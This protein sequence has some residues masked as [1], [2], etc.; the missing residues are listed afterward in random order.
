MNGYKEFEGKTLDDAI[1][2]ACSYYDSTRDRLE[3]EILNDSKYGIFGLVGAKKARIRAKLVQLP[4]VLD[5]IT[6]TP[7]KGRQKKAVATGG[8]VEPT[9]RKSRDM[10]PAGESSKKRRHDPAPKLEGQPRQQPSFEDDPFVERDSI[11]ALFAR[12]VNSAPAVSEREPEEEMIPNNNGGTRS[13]N[14][15]KPKRQARPQARATEPV[16]NEAE[17]ETENLPRLPLAQLDQELLTATA[18]EIVTKLTDSFLGPVVVSAAIDGDKVRI[19]ITDVETPGLLIGRDGQTLASLQYL[20]TR[21]LSGRMKTLLRV[22]IDAEDYRERQEERLR[23][24]ALSLAEKVKSSGRAQTTKPLSSYQRRVIHLS[25]QKDPQVQTHSKGEGELK[26]VMIT[27]RKA[28]K[29][30]K[31]PE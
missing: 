28:E 21:M 15:A 5:D 30:D 19:S 14:Q 9:P 13:R 16:A 22:Q 29:N 11:A 23:D 17:N 27:R 18:C 26:R 7:Q 6:P 4:S 24:L 1:N 25:L 2:D 12:G 3:I 20:V 31:S 8:A 10:P